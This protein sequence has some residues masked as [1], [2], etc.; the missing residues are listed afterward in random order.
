ME[1]ALD[2]DINAEMI[3]EQRKFHTNKTNSFSTFLKLSLLQYSKS[4]E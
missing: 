2:I 3:K 1:E 4:R